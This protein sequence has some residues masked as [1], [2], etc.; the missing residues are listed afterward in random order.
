MK[1]CPVCKTAVFDDMDVCYGCMHRFSA[2]EPEIGAAL[3]TGNGLLPV[4]EIEE[5][6]SD[7]PS[8]SEPPRLE[9]LQGA[10]LLRVELRDP[11]E[12]KRS[13]TFELAPSSG[14][15]RES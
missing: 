6:G 5:G 15:A 12:S 14:L 9:E 11:C 3:E 2:F 10:W 7:E 1:K 13:W 4:L 8:S